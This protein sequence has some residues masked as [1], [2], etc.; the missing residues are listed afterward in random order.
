MT[1]GI[2]YILNNVPSINPKNPYM[3]EKETILCVFL[4]H[5]YTCEGMKG[6]KCLGKYFQV[7][8]YYY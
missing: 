4:K 8:K 3:C 7:L 6:R 1:W 5:G 2:D